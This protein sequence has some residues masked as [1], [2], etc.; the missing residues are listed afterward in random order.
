LDGSSSAIIENVPFA[1]LGLDLK[2]VGVKAVAETN[3]I[4]SWW[5]NGVGTVIA[6]RLPEVLVTLIFTTSPCVY[7][8]LSVA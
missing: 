3:A 5:G 6:D 8:V 1:L 7:T 4:A 2:L